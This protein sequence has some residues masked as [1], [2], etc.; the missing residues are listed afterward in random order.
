MSRRQWWWDEHSAIHHVL[1]WAWIHV[2]PSRARWSIAQWYADHRGRCWCC[3][4]D[5]VH[6]A[7]EWADWR[8]DY[9]DPGCLCDF[10]MPWDAGP[11]RP[12]YC[13]CPPSATVP[14]GT[15]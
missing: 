4:Y 10:P 3:V 2:L 12:G 6:R 1:A 13:Y 8:G 11:P 5:S 14:S 15:V 9:E 7:D